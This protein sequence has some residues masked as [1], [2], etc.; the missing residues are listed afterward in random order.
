MGAYKLYSEEAYHSPDP[1][2]VVQEHSMYWGFFTLST[3]N[4]LRRKNSKEYVPLARRVYA[5]RPSS[6]PSMPITDGKQSNRPAAYKLWT[7][8]KIRLACEAVKCDEYTYSREFGV[9]KSTIR[10]RISGKTLPGATSG[11][12]QYLT[13]T[14]LSAI[15]AWVSVGCMV[16]TDN[17]NAVY[18]SISTSYEL[19]LCINR[20]FDLHPFL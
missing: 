11:P 16:F 10:D 6:K 12:E 14:E 20:K 8:E 19:L 13:D 17:L 1:P 4:M 2:I 9:P 3:V 5:T 7:E 15:K 18:F